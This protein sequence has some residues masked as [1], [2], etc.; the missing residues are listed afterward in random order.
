MEGPDSL[1]RYDYI[2]GDFLT[3]PN[4]YLLILGALG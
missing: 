1:V 3:C 4:G 2:A